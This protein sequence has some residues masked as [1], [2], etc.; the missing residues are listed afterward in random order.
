LDYIAV[1]PSY[2]RRGVGNALFRFTLKKFNSIVNNGVGL[3]ME[4]QREDG[5]ALEEKITRKSTIKF[6]MN[7]GGKILDGVRYLLP[8]LQYGMDPEEMYLIVRP[9]K[10]IRS[11]SKGCTLAYRCDIHYDLSISRQGSLYKRYSLVTGNA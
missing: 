6:Y 8:L 9:L 5:A 7:L 10:Q 1:I 11:L 4:V 2:H 3:L